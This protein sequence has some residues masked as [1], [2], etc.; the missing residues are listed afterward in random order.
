MKRAAPERA[1]D[2]DSATCTRLICRCF[3]IDDI[4]SD[5]VDD[6]ELVQQR[7]LSL[8]VA[9]GASLHSLCA[10]NRAWRFA[11]WALR[12]AFGFSRME[13]VDSGISMY[14]EFSYCEALIECNE[15]LNGY[16]RGA[17]KSQSRHLT[18]MIS[19]NHVSRA[20][21]AHPDRGSSLS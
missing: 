18:P 2:T 11:K 12:A 7:V 3:L 16:S 15:A 17:R 19:L 6:L 1:N 14:A 21:L 13:S 4:D 10:T 20:R 9:L 8:E 5:A